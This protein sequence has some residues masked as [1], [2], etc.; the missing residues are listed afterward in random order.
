M[1]N[2]DCKE[3]NN[4]NAIIAAEVR[5]QALNTEYASLMADL[6]ENKATV[7]G[8]S[9]VAG[10]ANAPWLQ[11]AAAPAAPAPWQQGF[12]QSVPGLGAPGMSS[13]PWMQPV[14]YQY[15]I[16]MGPPSDVPLFVPPPPL[17][18][19]SGLYA[20]PPPPPPK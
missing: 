11:A 19:P 14:A 2:E 4:P 15:T 5:D 20:A 17:A 13:A 7:S 3:K 16:P 6:G 1:S 9:R 10:L 12:N 8:S 18:A